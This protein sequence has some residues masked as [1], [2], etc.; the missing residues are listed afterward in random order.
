[1]ARGDGVAGFSRFA[2]DAE[3]RRGSLA[4]LGLRGWNV[5]R[6]ISIVR[7]RDGVL[8]PSAR[9]FLAMLRARWSQASARR[10][11]HRR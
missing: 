3:L 1:M 9:E 10:R 6:T 8:T 5:R 11:A 2:V 7:P 4:L